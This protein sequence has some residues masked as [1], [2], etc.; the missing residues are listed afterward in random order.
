MQRRRRVPFVSMEKERKEQD[1]LHM[2]AVA[3]KQDVKVIR[4]LSIFLDHHEYTVISVL[5]QMKLRGPI[6]RVANAANMLIIGGRR[7]ATVLPQDQK[8]SSSHTT[9][10]SSALSAPA[11]NSSWRIW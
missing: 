11:V 1:R 5:T 3:V 6:V 7:R 9:G 10:Q 4:A 8:S 2:S